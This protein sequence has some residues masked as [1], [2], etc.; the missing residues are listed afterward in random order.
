MG[1]GAPRLVV[2]VLDPV[3]AA[4][5]A[6]AVE[7]LHEV[8]Q[9]RGAQ[10]GGRQPDEAVAREEVHVDGRDARHTPARYPTTPAAQE[11]AF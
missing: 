1:V 11:G 10:D 4:S 5:R 8:R 7:Q 3:L 9:L 6:V 2:V